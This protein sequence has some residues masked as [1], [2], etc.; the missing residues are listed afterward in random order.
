[1][2][3]LAKPNF[4]RKT[5]IVSNEKSLHHTLVELRY[6]SV[7]LHRIQI[8]RNGKGPNCEPQILQMLINN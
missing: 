2:I 5:D 3:E 7:Q 6:D 8:V 1:M 4:K